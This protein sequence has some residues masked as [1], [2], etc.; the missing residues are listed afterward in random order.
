MEMNLSN[1]F[2]EMSQDEIMTV[3]GGGFWEAI[4]VFT[5][6]V[7]VGLSPFVGVCVGIAAGPIAGV[8]AGGGCASLGLSLIGSACH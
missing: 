8:S 3:D 2:C 1:G 6:G 7:A 4:K 5:G